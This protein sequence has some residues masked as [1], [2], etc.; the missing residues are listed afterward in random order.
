MLKYVVTKL[1]PE[2]KTSLVAFATTLKIMKLVSTIIAPMKS[3]MEMVI[4][5]RGKT[6]PTKDIITAT[7]APQKSYKCCTIICSQS[8]SNRFPHSMNYLQCPYFSG[9]SKIEATRLHTNEALG[10]VKRSFATNPMRN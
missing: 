10:Q 3:Q 2:T 5:M 6:L 7:L 8:I 1:T 9:G 4:T